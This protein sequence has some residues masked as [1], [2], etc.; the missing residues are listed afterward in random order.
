MDFRIAPMA[1]RAPQRRVRAVG[2]KR[3]DGTA[4]QGCMGPAARAPPAFLR[5]ST[6]RSHR[7][8]GDDG[9]ENEREPRSELDGSGDGKR[10]RREAVVATG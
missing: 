9:N 7:E 3:V 5:K 6:D 10:R 2:R 4:L 8:R 1:A